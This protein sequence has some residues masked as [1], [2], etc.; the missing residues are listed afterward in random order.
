MTVKVNPDDVS[1]IIRQAAEIEILPR[2]RDLSNTQIWEK[3]PGSIVTEADIAAEKYLH[4]ELTK[5]LPGTL[6]GEEA[7]AADPTVLDALGRDP[8]VWII[9][10]VDGTKNFS[11][12]K[13]RF[14]VIVALVMNGETQMGWIYDP[15]TDRMVHAVKGQGAW[16]G[17]QRLTVPTDGP[18][19]H[20]KGSAHFQSPLVPHVAEVGRSGSTGHD[21]I[22]LATRALDFAY[23]NRMYPW[24]HA[25]GILIH[26][27]AGGVSKHVDGTEYRPVP[28]DVNPVIAAPAPQSWKE[29]G[30]KS[31]PLPADDAFLQGFT[32]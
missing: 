11:K 19:K 9:D 3:E 15:V 4:R 28:V 14:A 21:Y 22:D 29:L 12:G 25:A 1:R 23:F 27:E 31:D 30:Q 13:P 7:T 6:V 2:F 10:P 5:I 26:S 16:C 32:S 24:D 20:M 18:I 17:K 8:V